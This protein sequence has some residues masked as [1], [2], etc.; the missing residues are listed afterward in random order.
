MTDQKYLTQ[1]EM[2]AYLEE[3]GIKKSKSWAEHAR[4]NKRGPKFVRFGGH[5]RTTKE[6]IEEWVESCV[7]EVLSHD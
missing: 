5:V 1:D 2:L 6:F 7:K 3:L 4:F